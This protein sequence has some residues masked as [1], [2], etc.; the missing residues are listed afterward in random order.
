M[1][2]YEKL[3]YESQAQ[4]ADIEEELRKLVLRIQSLMRQSEEQILSED[5]HEN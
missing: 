2:D 4:L 1:P 5:E 3:F